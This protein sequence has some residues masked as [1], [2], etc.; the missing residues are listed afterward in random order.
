VLAVIGENKDWKR[1]TPKV[2]NKL[3]KRTEPQFSAARHA[4]HLSSARNG[5]KNFLSSIFWISRGIL[6]DGVLLEGSEKRYV[7]LSEVLASLLL[8]DLFYLWKSG[9]NR[10]ASTHV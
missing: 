9:F 3:K 1:T 7:L 8:E 2:Q 5:L 4:R 10:L 6:L